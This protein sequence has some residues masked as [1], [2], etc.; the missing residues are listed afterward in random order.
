MRVPRVTMDMIAAVVVLAQRRNLEA[1]GKELGLTASAVHKRIQAANQI[2]TSRLFTNTTDG[3][4]LTEVGEVFYA[5]AMKAMEQV[6][7]VE[8]TSIAASHLQ[9]NHILVGHSTYLPAR[10]LALLHDTH[11]ISGLG[12]RM[13]HKP[14]LTLAMAQSVA[15]G[16]LHAG[17]GFL[18]IAHA[19]LLVHP[20][21][22]EPVAVC[23]VSG[24]PLATKATI[25][26][27]DLDGEP[28]IAT[29]RETFPVLHQQIEEFF[30]DFGIK[31]N[32]VADA[33]GPPEAVVMAEH[34]VGICLLAASNIRA[35]SSVV[36]KPLSPQTLTRRCGLF[37]R[38]DNRH[39]VLKSFVDL[40]LQRSAMWHS[41]K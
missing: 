38:Q 7:L 20:V 4:R 22:E 27:Q 9:A 18:P 30:Q 1:A 24:H 17:L 23:M 29:G 26:P 35:K 10:L 33:F 16:T 15:K 6:L 31:L 36:A 13:E 5:H 2:F 21:A 32:I 41:A 11:I 25:R 37:V 14:G 8:E 19:D 12:I 40:I 39:P 34:K 3:V 28:I